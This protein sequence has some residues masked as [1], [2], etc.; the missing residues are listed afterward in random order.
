MKAL[1][2]NFEQYKYDNGTKYAMNDVYVK[3]VDTNTG[4][5]IGD[6]VLV[7]DLTDNYF[8]VITPAASSSSE[9]AYLYISQNL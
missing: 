9:K 5:Q 2:I 7:Q 6:L 8:D 4:D 1:G 3:F